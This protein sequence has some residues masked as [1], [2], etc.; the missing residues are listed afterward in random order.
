MLFL[1]AR[2]GRRRVDEGLE[3]AIRMKGSLILFLAKTY[4]L[5]DKAAK[6]MS[7]EY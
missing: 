2:P 6:T 3:L 5:K 1:S 7:N 4:G